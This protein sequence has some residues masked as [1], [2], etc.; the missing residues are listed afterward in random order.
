MENEKNGKNEKIYV[1]KGRKKTTQYGELITINLSLDNIP[2]QFVR[3]VN[4][5]RYVNLTVTEMKNPDPHGNTL[6]VKVDTFVKRQKEDDP[7]N[8]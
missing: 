2:D 3:K 7:F 8:F 1:G 4:G 5:K 6:T